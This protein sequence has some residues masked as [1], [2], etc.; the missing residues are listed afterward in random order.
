MFELLGDTERYTDEQPDQKLRDYPES[1]ILF[2]D[3]EDDPD[4]PTHSVTMIN[5]HTTKGLEFLFVY[6][7]GMAE[8]LYPNTLAL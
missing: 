3:N 5:M 1:M 4:Q 2:V 8:G 6:V 7:I